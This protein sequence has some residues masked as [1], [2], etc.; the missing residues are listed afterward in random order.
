MRDARYYEIRIQQLE[1]DIEA[2]GPAGDDL[3]RLSEYKKELR[4]IQ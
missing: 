4:E 1:D 3:Y 2:F